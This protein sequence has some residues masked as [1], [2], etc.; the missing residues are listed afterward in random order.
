MGR[1]QA[2]FRFFVGVQSFLDLSLHFRDITEKASEIAQVI[3]EMPC[4][5][6]LASELLKVLAGDGDGFGGLSHGNSI[7]ELRIKGSFIFVFL[8]SIRASVSSCSPPSSSRTMMNSL[9]IKSMTPQV[10]PSNVISLPSF[11]S[12]MGI[13]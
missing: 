1:K 13:L 8:Q 10:P 9:S 11:L 5:I 12:V 4:G 7:A 3:A 2:L 6:L